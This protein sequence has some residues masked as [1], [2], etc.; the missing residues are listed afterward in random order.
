MAGDREN[1]G[2][3]A[4]LENLKS[5]PLFF[6]WGP[7]IGCFVFA[8]HVMDLVA[9]NRMSPAR[10]SQEIPSRVFSGHILSMGF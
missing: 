4:C 1:L 8:G 2:L 7:M 5:T 9:K 6:A 3:V 10:C